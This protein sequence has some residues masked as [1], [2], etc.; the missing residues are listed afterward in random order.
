MA[1]LSISIQ[2]NGSTIPAQLYVDSGDTVSFFSSYDAVVC[3]KSDVFD[4]E[5]LEVPSNGSAMVR[6]GKGHD[7]SRVS[8]SVQIGNLAAKCA[9]EAVG[10]DPDVHVGGD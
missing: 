2:K 7:K 1:E 4:Q 6:V 5:R 10:E 9:G 3:F 8:F